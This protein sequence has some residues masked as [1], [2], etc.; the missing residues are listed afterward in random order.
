MENPD[1]SLGQPQAETE[2]T[3]ETYELRRR[4]LLPAVRERPVLVGEE[5]DK[6]ADGPAD[7]VGN[8][9]VESKSIT[10]KR[11]DGEVGREAQEPDK[12]VEHD[13]AQGETEATFTRIRWLYDV[14]GV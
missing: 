1:E 6:A 14:A 10:E 2:D 7:A 9:W 3:P 5:A 12:Q 11:E 8:Q 4:R 13:T